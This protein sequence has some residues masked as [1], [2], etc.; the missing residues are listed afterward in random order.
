MR[1]QFESK[2]FEKVSEKVLRDKV[3]N[4]EIEFQSKSEMMRY[5]YDNE[6]SIADI[7]RFMNCHYSFVYGVIS[8]SREI[9]KET[10]DS[11][12]DTIRK[13]FD[14]GKKVGEIAKELNSNYSF[15]FGVV[16]KYKENKEVK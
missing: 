3:E 2:R 8:S 14:E 15:V 12:S 7:Q 13:M 5:L 9:K 10:K 16:K 11:K 6:V 1:V 4:K